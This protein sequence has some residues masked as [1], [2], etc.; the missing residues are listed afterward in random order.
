MYSES[1]PKLNPA[2]AWYSSNVGGLQVFL[3]SFILFPGVSFV[4]AQDDVNV[5][6]LPGLTI[7]APASR[8][9][10]PYW[11]KPE[12]ILEGNDLRRKRDTGLGDTLSRELGVSS[13]SYGPGASRPIIRG[14]DSSRIRV[15]ESGV[16][17]GDLSAI[18]PDH[19][20]ST[21]TLN[22]SQIEI[23]R[24]P[25]TLLYGSGTSGGVVNVISDHIPDR[26]YKSVQ[27]NFEGRF[28]SALEERSGAFSASGTQG[29]FSWNIEGA[30]RKTND[31][32]IPGRANINNP[33]SEFGIVENSAIDSGNISVGSSYIGER[34]YAGVS[35]SHLENFYGIPGPEGAKIDMGQTRYGLAGELDNPFKGFQLLKLR[36]NYNDYQHNELEESGEIGTRLKNDELDGRIELL[37]APLPD[38]QG[39]IGLQFQHQDFSAKGEEAFIPSTSSH[40]V[41]LFMLEQY[42]WRRW[43]FE[44][45][46]RYEHTHLNPLGSDLSS[47]DFNL[48]NISAGGGW[49]FIDGY[50]ID[51]T[52]TR[53]QRAP[54]INALYANGI[55]VATNT[56]ELG[57]QH[58][59]K[60]TSNN[61]EL[62][63]Q[64]TDGIVTGRINLFY[65]HINDYIFQQSRD[66]NSDGL[67]DR[68]N[69]EGELTVNGAF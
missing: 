57:D 42:Q 18:S 31:I 1:K 60:E 54:I 67:A 44:I 45:G 20:V 68:V 66:S 36:M 55:H 62:S 30:K 23:L 69:D 7:T 43:L 21:E 50:Q 16:S 51:F 28:N 17:M 34:G 46:G 12:K 11:V 25:S 33:D 24:G 41:G 61:F 64:K 8:K 22:A 58:L 32:K 3:S 38:W 59:T 14:L 65:N 15:L 63:L 47:R 10:E 37:H 39:V 29:A 35:I 53:G 2:R 13:S 4:F 9:S 49:E 27:G 56:F 6:E 26:L 52:A 48:F 19:A 40:A 5:T